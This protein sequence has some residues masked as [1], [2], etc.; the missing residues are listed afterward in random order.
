MAD[1]SE[2]AS[3]ISETLLLRMLSHSESPSLTEDLALARIF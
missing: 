2:L 1:A 3:A